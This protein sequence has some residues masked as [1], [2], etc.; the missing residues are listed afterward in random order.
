MSFQLVCPQ[1]GIVRNYKSRQ[2]VASA[3]Y[4]GNKCRDCGWKK[5]NVEKIVALN[6]QG[7]TTRAIAK[8]LKTTE[9]VVH[10]WLK[11]SGLRSARPAFHKEITVVGVIC[12]I[13]KTPKPIEQYTGLLSYCN[14]CK[15][16]KIKAREKDNLLLFFSRVAS[17]LKRRNKSKGTSSLV[18]AE[19]LVKMFNEQKGKCFYSDEE[20]RPGRWQGRSLQSVSVDRVDVNR[21]YEGN[22]IV[23]C[24]LRSNIIKSNQSLDELKRWM[25]SWHQKLVNKGLIN[26]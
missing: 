8:E 17:V 2:C 12:S 25:P 3:K 20:M 11:R 18:S 19:L 26:E 15:N 13:C 6:K 21:G 16:D 14:A 22:N 10:K 5:I 1:C 23:L 24:T 4:K 9:A 7:M